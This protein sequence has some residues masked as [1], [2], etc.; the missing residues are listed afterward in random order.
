MP[1]AIRPMLLPARPVLRLT[2]SHRCSVARHLLALNG[3]DRY[4]RFASALSDTGIA[5]YVQSIDFEQDPCFGIVEPEGSLSGFIHLAVW[6]DVAELAASVLPP[7]RRRGQAR[8]LIDIA[9]CFAAAI[10]IREVHLA[11]GHPA[12]RH[13][14]SG[15]GHHILVGSEHPRVRFQLRQ[16]NRQGLSA[17]SLPFPT[18]RDEPFFCGC[19]A[20]NGVRNS[21]AATTSAHGRPDG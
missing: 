17:T 15:L 4:S 12:V 11:T 18:R 13:I 8:Q 9:L 19:A 6:E 21:R 16:A 5:L 2:S 7:W 20:Q 3:D 10:G 14:C 1:D